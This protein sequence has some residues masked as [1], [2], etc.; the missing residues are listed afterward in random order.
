[1]AS[2]ERRPAAAQKRSPWA[3]VVFVL[4]VTLSAFLSLLAQLLLGQT[5]LILALVVLLV[6]ILLGIAFAVFLV[7]LLL[8]TSGLHPKANYFFT[9]ETEGNPLLEIFHRWVPLPY[10]YLIPCLGILLPY[11]LLVTLPFELLDRKRAR[12]DEK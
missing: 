9:M 3:G 11:M 4:A 5:G 2:P 7:N 12:A 6:F 8:R 1:M 10:L